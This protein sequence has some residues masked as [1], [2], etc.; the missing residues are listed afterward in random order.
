MAVQILYFH[1]DKKWFLA[2]VMRKYGKIVPEYGCQG[3]WNRVHH[4]NNI[5][6]LLVICASAV[7]P[8]DNDLRKGGK[9]YKVCMSRAG[10]EVA[11]KQ[12]SYQ[13][14]YR[15]DGTWHYPQI[16]ESLLR[17]KKGMYF[18]TMEITGS[19]KTRRTVRCG[20]IRLL[21]G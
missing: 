8:F 20:S 11:A 7:A 1:I 14:V 16:A 18:K 21:F 17:R 9:G 2:L 5:D 12:D 4:K 15:D 10:G 6:K 3:V 13:R 19:K